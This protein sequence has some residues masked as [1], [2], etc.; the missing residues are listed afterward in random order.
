LPTGQKKREVTPVSAAN[1]G[2]RPDSGLVLL[3]VLGWIVLLALLVT[4]ITAAT[5][6]AILISTN[7][8]DSAVAEAWADGAVN[9]AIF[10]VLARQWKADGSTYLVRGALA[11]ARVRIDDE[12]GKID[13]NVAP[14]ALL[15]ALLREC[16]ATAKTATELAAAI[17]DWR[18]LD[19]LRSASTAAASRYRAAG[20]GYMPPH[21][22]FV[23]EDE[24]G[25]VLGMTPELLAC[26]EP[27]T[28]V[29]SLSVPS[30]ETTADPV[31][32]RALLDAYPDDTP[33]VVSSTV[34]EL[35]VIRVTAIAEQ[36]GGRGRFRRV[37]V[38]RIV[39][40]GP[41]QDFIYRIL[42]WEGSAD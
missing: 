7:I 32:R 31:V 10:Q 19:L 29:Y 38:V 27:H 39:P 35:A 16:G 37:A 13:P 24:M 2:A 21:A 20:R 1:P 42:F 30:L 11:V 17:Y 41:D 18:S 23:S 26:V 33:Q 15:Q 12:G 9:E 28:S 6:T 25:L 34:R 36:K 5:R 40:A 4:R 8:R 22:R 14:V 3:I